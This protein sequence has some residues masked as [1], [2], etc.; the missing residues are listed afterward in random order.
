MVVAVASPVPAAHNSLMALP[1][2]HKVCGC[3]ARA[4][5]A[6]RSGHSARS[7]T[8]PQWA[9]NAIR[10]TSMCMCVYAHALVP[11]CKS[12]SLHLEGGPAGL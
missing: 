10:Y 11:V 6:P 8:C 12:V 7:G 1:L 9:S 2:T 4:S 3:E 5:S